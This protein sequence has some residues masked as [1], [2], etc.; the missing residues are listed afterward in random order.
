M[1]GTPL[2]RLPSCS[3]GTSGRRH[4]DRIGR[5]SSCV[6]ACVCMR[7]KSRVAGHTVPVPPP[8]VA[9][10]THVRVSSCAHEGVAALGGATVSS[11]GRIPRDDPHRILLAVLRSAS[12]IDAIER[13]GAV[14]LLTRIR[15]R[16]R[17]PKRTREIPLGISRVSDST[18]ILPTR[19]RALNM[20]AMLAGYICA[21]AERRKC[22]RASERPDRAPVRRMI[23][24]RSLLQ[25]RVVR[26][27]RLPCGRRAGLAWPRWNQ[28]SLSLSLSTT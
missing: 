2:R 25:L 7:T 22:N 11:R 1:P 15:P 10:A 18:R 20:S 27:N 24:A 4:A 9:R 19:D 12:R 13:R 23:E 5:N 28:I 26:F 8:A 3:R 6:R 17:Q 14:R 16:R 21:C